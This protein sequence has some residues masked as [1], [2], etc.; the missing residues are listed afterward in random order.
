[1]DSLFSL[2]ESNQKGMGSISIFEDGKEV[3]SNAFGYANIEENKKASTNTKYRIGSISKMFT[4]SIIMK[5]IE[6]GN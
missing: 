3:Y 5:L 1:M 4:A 2:I 6:E